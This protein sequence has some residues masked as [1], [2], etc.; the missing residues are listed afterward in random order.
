M[1]EIPKPCSFPW[2]ERVFLMEDS[3]AGG[4]DQGLSFFSRV[5]F[6]RSSAALYVLTLLLP[7]SAAGQIRPIELEGIV[8]TGTPVP[9][10]VGSVSSNVT[11]LEG[12]E[13][14]LRGVTGVAEAL[15]EVPG[16]VVVRNGSYGSLASS[17][18]RGA[19]SDHVKV[20]VDG[21]E[22]NQAGGAFDLSGLLVSDVER[23]EVVRGPASALYGSDA[24]AGVIQI[25]TRRGRG[26]RKASLSASGGS[27]GR[28]NWTADIHGA[29][30]G[31]DQQVS[32]VLLLVPRRGD[33][34]IPARLAIRATPGAA[35]HLR[36]P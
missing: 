29:A 22:L 23:I 34:S 9:R 24:M 18:F 14:R 13:L 15:A 21:V 35:Q 33:R 7:P 30:G 36:A 19:E 10:S 11:V 5:A 28:V 31:A 32:G 8:V 4:N 20:L 26:R 1:N 6:S 16:L 2:R 17:Y 12:D 3:R 25:I 27:Y